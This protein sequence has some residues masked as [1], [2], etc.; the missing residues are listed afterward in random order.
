MKLTINISPSEKE[1]VDKLRKLYSVNIS[2]MLR[3]AI[4]RQYAEFSDSKNRPIIGENPS[5]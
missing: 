2:A 3:N 5:K 4:K 1:T